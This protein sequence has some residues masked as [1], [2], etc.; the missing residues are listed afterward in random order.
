MDT[1]CNPSGIIAI[2]N[3]DNNKLI[4]AF[5]HQSQGHVYIGNIISNKMEEISKISSHDSKIACLSIN[6]EGT[7]LATTSD[8]GTI[9]RI[10]TTF[11]GVK[12]CEFRLGTKNVTMNCLTFDQNNKFIGSTSNAGSLHIFSIIGIMKIIK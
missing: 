5:P 6:K 2:S 7:I 4:I 3:G 12:F 1:F 9:I 8:K 10:F 11:G